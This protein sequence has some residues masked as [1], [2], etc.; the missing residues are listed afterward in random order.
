[1]VW[2]AAGC[3]RLSKWH[4]A[5]FLLH[6]YHICPSYTESVYQWYNNLERR[7]RLVLLHWAGCRL[8][9]KNPVKLQPRVYKQ[10][11]KLC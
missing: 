3:G 9:A 5:T 11:H 2:H 1:M 4:H 8:F 6:S 10:T 7:T